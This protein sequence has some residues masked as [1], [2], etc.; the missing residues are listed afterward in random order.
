MDQLRYNHFDSEAEA[1]KF[2]AQLPVYIACII[3]DKPVPHEVHPWIPL[4]L[5]D[6]SEVFYLQIDLSNVLHD[7]PYELLLTLGLLFGFLRDVLQSA[8][9]ASTI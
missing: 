2:Q 1:R 7:G 3:F 8:T 5:L 4:V 6:Q 9:I